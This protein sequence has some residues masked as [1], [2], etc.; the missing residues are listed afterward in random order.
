LL[1]ELDA[2]IRQDGDRVALRLAPP[3]W[4]ADELGRLDPA[5]GCALVD[6]AVDTALARRLP[7]GS[8]VRVLSMDLT[9]VRSL[10]L[11]E[12]VA[13][14]ATVRH[15]GRRLAVVD[16]EVGPAE[17]PPSVLARATVARASQGLP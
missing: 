11:Q 5:A 16:V 3:A 7:T 10:P 1:A 9:V 2:D 17:A 14:V 8:A 6:A 12:D 4:L 15:V 13:A